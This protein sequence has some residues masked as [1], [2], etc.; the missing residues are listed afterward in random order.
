MQANGQPEWFHT[1]AQQLMV[2]M[3]H[4]TQ[5]MDTLEQQAK[6]EPQEQPP[7]S[8]DQVTP[9]TTP[10]SAMAPTAT[11][12]SV[13]EEPSRRPRAKLPDMKMFTGKRSDW[14]AWKN[15]MEAKL[16]RD[17]LAIGDRRDRFA[18]IEACLDET[19]SKMVLAYVERNRKASS[20]DPDL[21]MAYLDSIY[22]DTNAKE[23]ANNKLNTMSQK[24]EAFATFLPKFERTLAEAG[25]G[26]W[27][28][29]VKINTLKRTLNQELRKSLIYIPTHPEQYNDFIQT[30]QTI[31][32]RLAAFDQE[33]RKPTA[34]TVPKP[35]IDEMDWQPSTNKVQAFANNQDEPKRAQWVSKDT[36]ER[37]KN[38]NLCLRCGGKGHFISSCRLLPAKLPQQGQTKVKVT[39]VKNNV[40]NGREE[41]EVIEELNSDTESGKE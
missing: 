31:A 40:E 7:P 27:T 10:T 23:Q 15:K 38:S 32:S 25:G 3:T 17:Q 19:A 13:S 16:D 8:V 26:E 6:R 2:H 21:L 4:I 29:E 5:R 14:R 37:R 22:G 20:E 36:L 9:T 34:P 1:W 30:L 28:D 18:Y 35:I 39:D 33:P 24:K 11:D 12:T 41:V